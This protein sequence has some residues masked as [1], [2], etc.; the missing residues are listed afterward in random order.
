ML[1]SLAIVFIASSGLFVTANA[2][3]SEKSEQS[4]RPHL[5]V[6][7]FNT[8]ID[9]GAAAGPLVVYSSV[10]ILQSLESIYLIAAVALFGV[11]QRYVW[12]EERS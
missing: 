10:A 6:G 3:A 12:I 8:A 7:F 1:A 5:F 4:S 9:A 11:I 2:A